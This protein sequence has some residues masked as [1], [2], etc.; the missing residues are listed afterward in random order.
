VRRYQKEELLP[1][2]LRAP[3]VEAESDVVVADPSATE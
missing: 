1:P 3:Q 2:L